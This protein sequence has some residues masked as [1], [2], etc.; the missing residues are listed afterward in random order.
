[1]MGV[2]RAVVLAVAALLLQLTSV[3]A[4][5]PHLQPPKHDPVA[6][7]RGLIQRRLGGEYV[8]QVQHVSLCRTYCTRA[9][10]TCR[11]RLD[12]CLNGD[13]VAPSVSLFRSLFA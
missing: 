13:Y 9:V 3:D 12:A 2:M 1:M 6:A 7:T 5:R 11:R 10:S 4:L 8:D